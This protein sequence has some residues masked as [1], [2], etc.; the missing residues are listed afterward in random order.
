MYIIIC[1]YVTTLFEELKI[2]YYTC[3]LFLFYFVIYLYNKNMLYLYTINIEILCKKL[4]YMINL[5]CIKYRKY[6]FSIKIL[7]IS[8]N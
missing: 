8:F 5:A 6:I 1:K 4:I 7:Y 2:I 3:Q